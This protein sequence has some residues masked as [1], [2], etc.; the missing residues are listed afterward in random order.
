M[1]Y[2]YTK[3]AFLYVFFYIIYINKNDIKECKAKIYCIKIHKTEFY[4]N[5]KRTK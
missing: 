2:L 4:M 5:I 3:G 1:N